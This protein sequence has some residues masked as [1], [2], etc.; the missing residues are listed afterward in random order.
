MIISNISEI[1]V[2]IDLA[3]SEICFNL[4]FHDV[5]IGQTL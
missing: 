3:N 2:K 4:K 5:P 1:R